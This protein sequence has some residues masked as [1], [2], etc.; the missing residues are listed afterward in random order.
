MMMKGVRTMYEVWVGTV[1]QSLQEDWFAAREPTEAFESVLLKE[2]TTLADVVCTAKDYLHGE[3][4][5][6]WGSWIW[7]GTKAEIAALFAV[8]CSTAGISLAALQDDIKYAVA[9]IES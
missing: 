6:D 3:Y 8:C 5:V 7:Y 9:Y 1:S 4:Q 2:T